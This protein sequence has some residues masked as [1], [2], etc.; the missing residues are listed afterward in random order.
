MGIKV[1]IIIPYYQNHNLLLNCVNSIIQQSVNKKAY[2]II[3]I[4]DNPNLRLDRNIF[5]FKNLIII[6]NNS[7]LGPGL[8]RNKGINKSKGKYILF[9]DSDD[10]VKSDYLKKIFNYIDKY[11]F[12]ILTFNSKYN[13]KLID[14]EKYFILKKFLTAKI[15]TS[16]IYSIFKKSLILK[17]KI[18]FKAG[19][20][21]DIYFLFLTYK[22]SNKI[23]FLKSSFYKKNNI[24]NSIINK[25]SKARIKDYFEAYNDITLI[26][27]KDPFFKNKYTL[28]KY[29]NTGQNGYFY[30]IINEIIRLE[31]NIAIIN[32][33]IKHAIDLSK[34]QFNL[35]NQLIVSK[36]NMF[37][38]FFFKIYLDKSIF[39]YEDLKI[40]KKIE[41]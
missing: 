20:H 23:K 40:L 18:Y 34:D 32:Q 37:N 15:D 33:L 8:S 27:K 36:K 35:T 28:N 17:N 2:E 39:T 10:L 29:I 30:D 19:V 16:V 41:I 12:D 13:K 7:N 5:L 4:N 38:K 31:N 3:I 25:I 6:N 21:E 22:K 14:N 9:V 1:S 11:D 24:N 26:C